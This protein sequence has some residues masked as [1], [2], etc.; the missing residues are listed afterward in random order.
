LAL[1][2]TDSASESD[3]ASLEIETSDLRSSTFP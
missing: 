3:A 2:A 1:L